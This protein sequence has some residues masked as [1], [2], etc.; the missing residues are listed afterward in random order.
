VVATFTIAFR[1]GDAPLPS[2][3]APTQARELRAIAVQSTGADGGEIVVHP[4]FEEA[5]TWPF[6]DSGN[7]TVASQVPAEAGVVLWP[8]EAA[9]PGGFSPLEG[10]W[11]L[12]H[13]VDPPTSSWLRFFKWYADRYSLAITPEPVAVYVKERE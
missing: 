9:A 3:L 8:P 13:E 7:V 6:R 1:A 5:L 10:Q 2:P 11:A 12:V 4:D